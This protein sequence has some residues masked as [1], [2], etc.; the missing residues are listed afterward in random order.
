MQFT[1]KFI[2]FVDVLGFKEHVKAAENGSG[3]SLPELLELVRQLGAP[4]DRDR[5][6]KH[7]PTTCPQSTFVQRDLDFRVTQISDCVIVSAETSPAGLI[8]LLSHCWG[9][10]IRLL[11]KGVLCRG[12]ITRGSVYHTDSQIIGSGYQNAY[13]NERTVSAF[14]LDSEDR[15]TPFVEVDPVVCEY[16][17]A[18]GDRCVKE[19]FSRMVKTDGGVTALFPFQRISHGFIIDSRFDAEKEFAAN[20]RVREGIAMLKERVLAMVDKNNER[21]MRKVRHYIRALDGQLEIC[22]RTD[23]VIRQLAGHR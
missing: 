5:F 7:G 22:D 9:A 21:A 19:M 8:N 16:V 18:H 12:F 15:G 4:E 6:V 3:V 14:A 20:Q 11:Y 13:E 1:E 17:N 10:A 23:E 2:A